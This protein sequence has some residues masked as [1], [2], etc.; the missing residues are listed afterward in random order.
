MDV[1]DYPLY[2]GPIII[3]RRGGKPKEICSYCKKEKHF[4]MMIQ[5]LIML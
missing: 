1:V 4:Y 2:S 3:E 5:Q